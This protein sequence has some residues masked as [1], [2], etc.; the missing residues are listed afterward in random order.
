MVPA[1]AETGLPGTNVLRTGAAAG[2]G[3][4]SP[5]KAALDE[6][7]DLGAAVIGGRE[8]VCGRT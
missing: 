1:V 3:E 8:P 4:V 7:E 5:V 2:S 6:R